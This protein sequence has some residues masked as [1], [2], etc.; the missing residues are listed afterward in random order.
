VSY[1][2]SPYFRTPLSP[3]AEVRHMTASSPRVMGIARSSCPSLGEPNSCT[4]PPR[5]GKT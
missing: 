5:S 4:H 1:S 2:V 3:V